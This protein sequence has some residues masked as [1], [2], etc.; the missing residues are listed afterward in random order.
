MGCDVK[1]EDQQQ[2]SP[3]FVFKFYFYPMVFH[4]RDVPKIYSFPIKNGLLCQP[5]YA[6]KLILAKPIQ[7]LLA[8]VSVCL[9]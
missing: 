9:V 6:F 5:V 2:T 8:I 4:F 7:K 1:G 3:D